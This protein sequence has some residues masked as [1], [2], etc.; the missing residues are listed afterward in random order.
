MV[1]ATLK[2]C[3]VAPVRTLY[4]S[5]V[6]HVSAT[7]KALWL[8]RAYLQGLKL[9]YG[10]LSPREK[11]GRS[12]LPWVK[13]IRLQFYPMTFFAYAAGAFAGANQMN[14]WSTAVFWLGYLLLF[15]FEVIVV[16]NNEYHDQK[17]DRLNRNFSPFSGGSRVL[18]DGEI[19]EN[20]LKN[21]TRWLIFL[22]IAL[23]TLLAVVSPQSWSTTMGVLIA[24]FLLAISYTA[25]PLQL[26]YRGLGELVVG[27]THSFAVILCGFVFQGG[28]LRETLP[29]LLGLPLFLAIVPAIILAGVPDYQADQQAG[30]RTLVV[31][32]GKKNAAYLALGFVL[33]APISALWTDTLAMGDGTYQFGLIFIAMH[34]LLLTEMLRRFAARADKPRRIDGLMIVA[35]LYIMWFAVFPF[36]RNWN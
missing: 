9:Q 30:K 28:P 16:F 6:K 33:L 23:A 14:R 11:I 2:F 18:V 13:A 17:T 19:T 27:V 20:L 7:R 29:W 1:N 32:M 12:A 26:S 24:V 21:V 5:P 35:L 15:V 4:F 3:G 22:A 34:A 25:P 31:R 10:L 8:H 36:I